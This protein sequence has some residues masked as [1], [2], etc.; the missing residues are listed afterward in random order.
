M[1]DPYMDFCK[2]TLS[3]S[4]LSRL[5]EMGVLPL[6]ELRGWMSW[7]GVGAPTEDTHKLVVF[8]SFFVH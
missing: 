3:E 7:K 8:A 6:K 2:S 5:V 4:N 1:P